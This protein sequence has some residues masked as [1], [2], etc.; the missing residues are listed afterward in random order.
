MEIEVKAVSLAD[1]SRRIRLVVR[2]DGER[3]DKK[4]RAENEEKEA[5]HGTPRAESLSPPASR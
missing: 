3:E 5:A 4:I 2:S 1:R